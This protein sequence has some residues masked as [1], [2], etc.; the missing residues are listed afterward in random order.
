MPRKNNPSASKEGRLP[1]LF[2]CVGRRIELLRAFRRAGDRLGLNLEIHGADA[3]LMSPGMHHVDQAH[4]VPLIN[5][6]KYIDALL[7]VVRK[8]KIKLLIP[9]VDSELLD[10]SR[11]V[12]RFAKAGCL[13]LVSRESVVHTCG[14]K[15]ATFRVLSEA[16]IDTPH[17]WTWAEA[18]KKPR[19]KFPY[20]MKPLAGSAAMGN[21]VIRNKLELQTFGKLV[22]RPIVQEFADGIEHTMD[23]YTGLDGVPRCVTPRRRLEIRAGEVSKAILVMDKAMMDVGTRVTEVLEG[24]RGVVTVQAIINKR[25]RIRVIEINARFGGGVPL[26]I[27]AGADYPRWILQELL[28]QRPRINPSSFRNDVAMLRFDD[29]VFV[30]DVSNVDKKRPAAKRRKK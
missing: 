6:G 20:Y 1:I 4:I 23:V 27:H 9:T 19:H 26:A 28:G 12:D 11:S 3:T 14:D 22:K 13:A 7:R 29:S 8:H 18:M 15:L 25:G 10:L 24:C 30:S 21:Y 5:T 16:G 2:T 17:T